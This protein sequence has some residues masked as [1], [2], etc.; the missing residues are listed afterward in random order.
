MSSLANELEE[1]I[2]PRETRI[3]VHIL[4]LVASTCQTI[5]KEEKTDK[6]AGNLTITFWHPFFL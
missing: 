5:S 1:P 3:H 6:D 2:L 4:E